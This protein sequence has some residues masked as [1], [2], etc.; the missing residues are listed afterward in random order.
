MYRRELYNNR[1]KSNVEDHVT[2]TVD[3]YRGWS[4]VYRRL[5]AKY[6][7]K[8]KESSILEL[9]A[10]YGFFLYFLKENGFN[11]IFGIDISSEPIEIAKKNG[12]NNIIYADIQDFLSSKEKAYDLIVAIDVLEHFKKEEVFNLLQKIYSSLREEG[13]LLL[14]VPN[15]DYPF[16]GGYQHGDFTHETTFTPKNMRQILQ[17]IG[18]KNILF[19][20]CDNYLFNPMPFYRRF[21]WQMFRKIIRFYI[22]FETNERINILSP[23]FIAIA[24]KILFSQNLDILL[25]QE[26]K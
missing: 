22:Y 5:Y 24:Q 8:D 9:G 12:I 19:K 6:L 15:G 3:T 20:Q 21:F 14:Q 13:I 4:S 7:P 11:N 10:G 2:I 25:T 18:F 26:K 1:L 23:N 16:G 17:V